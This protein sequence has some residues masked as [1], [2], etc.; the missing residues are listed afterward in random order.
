S[1]DGFKY[2]SCHYSWYTRYG[3]KGKDVPTGA[4]PNIQKDH[5]GRV[6]FD[7]RVP[8]L[9]KDIQQ[10]LNGYVL[11]A[12]AYTDFFELLWVVLKH[13]LPDDY[14]EISIYPEVL[15][16]DAASPAFPFAGFVVNV[17]PCTWGHHDRD[18]NLCFVVPFGPFKGGQ[19]CLYEAGLSFDLHLGDIMAFPSCDLTHFNLHFKGLR[20]T[21]V[22]HSDRQGD[23]WVRD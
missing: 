5:R 15:P 18:K 4:H 7:Q 3:E 9:S 14:N 17:C 11:L 8:H 6:N 20:G 10:D 13:Y 22:L 1:I 19:L 16:L 2:F 23:N 12:E 21:L